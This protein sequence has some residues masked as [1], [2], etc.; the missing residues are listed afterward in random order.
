VST[1]P[2]TRVRLD[3]LGITGDEARLVFMEPFGFFGYNPLHMNARCTISDSGTVSEEATIFGFP[4]LSIQQSTERPEALDS[5]SIVLAGLTKAGLVGDVAAV[6]QSW[7]DGEWPELP[8]D[9]AVRN[10]SQRVVN[11]IVR[12]TRLSPIWGRLSRHERF[13]QP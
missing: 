10:C 5:G 11:Q 7:D 12:T 6:L 4:A 13:W 9:C 2:R 3:A 1:H 8:D